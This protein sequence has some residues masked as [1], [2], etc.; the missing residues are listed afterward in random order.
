MQ[1][2]MQMIEVVTEDWSNTMKQFVWVVTE[3]WSN[4]MKQ[5]V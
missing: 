2:K 1:F 5:F 4:T 3:D